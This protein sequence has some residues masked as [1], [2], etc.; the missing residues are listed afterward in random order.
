MLQPLP[1]A[2]PGGRQVRVLKSS[3]LNEG[4]GRGKREGRGFIN[5]SV[6]STARVISLLLQSSVDNF[7]RAWWTRKKMCGQEAIGSGGDCG[8][9]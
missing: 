1:D 8:K 5:A 3:L 4:K 7:Y 9:V 2:D 6:L